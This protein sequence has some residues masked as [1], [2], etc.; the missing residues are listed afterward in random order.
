[1]SG[2]LLVEDTDDVSQCAKSALEELGY[3]VLVA[4]DSAGVLRIVNDGTHIDLLFTV[5]VR[6]SP[7]LCGGVNGRR[8]LHQGLKGRPG[9]A[10]L[11]TTGFTPKPILHPHP[12]RP[13]LSLF[14]QP[15]DL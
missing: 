6:R 12:T 14:S 8:L 1:M 11:F 9:L 4:H 10:G 5:I 13:D 2:G 3:K 7:L 15:K